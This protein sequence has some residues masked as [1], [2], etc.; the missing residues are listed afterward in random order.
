MTNNN[1]LLNVHNKDDA[2]SDGGLVSPS[3]LGSANAGQR[4]TR[5]LERNASVVDNAIQPFTGFRDKAEARESLATP[6]KSSIIN[7]LE[8]ESGVE[9]ASPRMKDGEE[10]E[11]EKSDFGNGPDI[12]I[13]SIDNTESQR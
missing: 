11:E 5:V 4:S 10:S 13:G 8:V 1:N 3:R 7:N 12:E 9:Q 6:T 2:N